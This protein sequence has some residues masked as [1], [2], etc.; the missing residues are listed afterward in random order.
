MVSVEAVKD[1]LNT[2]LTSADGEPKASVRRAQRVNYC[3]RV[4]VVFEEAS[5]ARTMVTLH[6][7]SSRGLSFSWPHEIP[8][9]TRFTARLERP[10]G[11]M[12]LIGCQVVHCRPREQGQFNIGAEF[13]QI[14]EGGAIPTAA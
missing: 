4:E 6:D 9:G 5:S 12:A 8:V 2:L 10:D 7:I 13:K 3:G 14:I 1:V 11:G